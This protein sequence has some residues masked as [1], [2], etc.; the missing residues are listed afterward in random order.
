MFSTPKRRTTRQR[1][2]HTVSG[3]KTGSEGKIVQTCTYNVQSARL[4]L[5]FDNRIVDLVPQFTEKIGMAAIGGYI[6][7]EE[8]AKISYAIKVLDPITGTLL[9]ENNKITE[10]PQG[11]WSKF[12]IHVQFDNPHHYETVILKGIISLTGADTKFLEKVHFLGID[13]DL[14]TE[15]ESSSVAV[16]FGEDVKEDFGKKTHLSSPELYYWNHEQSFTMEPV[17]VE[18]QVVAV[19]GYRRSTRYESMQSLRTLLTN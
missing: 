7:A 14:V 18:G 12:G 13:L 15:Y 5:S 19:L 10:L 16:N 2:G 8:P 3:E 17:V 11:S 4:I 9:T 6:K 1:S